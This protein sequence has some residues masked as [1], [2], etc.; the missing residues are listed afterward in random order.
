MTSDASKFSD[1]MLKYDGYVTYDDNNK[2]RILGYGE[3]GDD[4]SII[5]H[6]VHYVEGLKHNL[7]SISK[8]CDRGHE[9]TFEPN[10]YLIC[11]S[12]MIKLC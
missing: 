6:N 3:I 2:G 8:L 10:L 7:L 1:L 4:A 9:V 5:I 12:K 11:E